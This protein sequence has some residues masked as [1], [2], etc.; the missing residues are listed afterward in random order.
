M[1]PIVVRRNSVSSLRNNTSRLEGGVNASSG[2]TQDGLIDRLGG[3][4]LTVED[5]II[6][7]PPNLIQ[8]DTKQNRP[9]N[10]GIKLLLGCYVIEKPNIPL[11]LIEKC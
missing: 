3:A 1:P 7:S 2:S 8:R 5:E 10:P 4:G 9:R 11:S 6:A